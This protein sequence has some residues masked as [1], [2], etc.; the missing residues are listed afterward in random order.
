MTDRGKFSSDAGM[1]FN[2]V[3]F[4]GIELMPSKAMEWVIF[5]NIDM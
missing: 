1:N 2:Y 4:V 5:N 3:Q